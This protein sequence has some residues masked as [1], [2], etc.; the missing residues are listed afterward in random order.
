M[1]FMS[2]R[3]QLLMPGPRNA[4]LGELPR[5]NFD[6]SGAPTAA[7]LK[8]CSGVRWSFG[9][10]APAT[11]SGRTPDV[12]DVPVTSTPRPPPPVIS[13]VDTREYVNPIGSPL[14]KDVTPDSSQLSRT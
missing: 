5:S 3:S 2:D 13:V 8:A 12:A 1:F 11:M 9:R 7:T 14:R 6:A 10:T 4:S